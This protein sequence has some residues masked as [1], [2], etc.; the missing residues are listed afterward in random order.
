MHPKYFWLI[1]NRQFVNE[2]DK[3]AN[4]LIHW[5]IVNSGRRVLVSGL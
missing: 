3:V 4:V 1:Q 5:G 2:L